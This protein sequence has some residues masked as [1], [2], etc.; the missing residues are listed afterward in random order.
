MVKLEEHI[1]KMEEA[2]KQAQNSKGIKRK[3]LT[4]HYHRLLKEYKQCLLY[5]EKERK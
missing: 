1:K 4:K 3:Q 2:K 5:L